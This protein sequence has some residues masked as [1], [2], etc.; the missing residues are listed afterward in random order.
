MSPTALV[1][2]L[3]HKLTLLATT[4]GLIALVC[5]FPGEPPRS[6]EPLFAAGPRTPTSPA[7]ASSPS[8][9]GLGDLPELP[10]LAK[11]VRRPAQ[12]TDKPRTS[13]ETL[14]AAL[15]YLPARGGDSGYVFHLDVQRL[16]ESG[17]L[18]EWGVREP[19][20]EVAVDEWRFPAWALGVMDLRAVTLFAQCEEDLDLE[21][22]VLA[23]ETNAISRIMDLRASLERD[24]EGAM[25]RLRCRANNT[26][27]GRP[28]KLDVTLNEGGEY[29]LNFKPSTRLDDS[30]TYPLYSVE[31]SL[32]NLW[33]DQAF[34][35]PEEGRPFRLG[36]Y[37]LSNGTE[38]RLKNTGGSGHMSLYRTVYHE[39]LHHKRWRLYKVKVPSL[40]GSESD[41]FICGASPKVGLIAEKSPEL[42]SCLDHHFKRGRSEMMEFMRT[43]D[44]SATAVFALN[45]PELSWRELTGN[46]VGETVQMAKS[47]PGWEPEFTRSLIESVTSVES[48]AVEVY[49]EPREVVAE[50]TVRVPDAEI[51]ALVIK[52]WDE[53]ALNMTHRSEL[54]D[55][56]N[57]TFEGYV[58]RQVFED[59]TPRVEGSTIRGSVRLNRQTLSALSPENR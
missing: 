6:P 43:L 5:V 11:F 48:A 15:S 39:P 19:L 41:S 46:E 34:T 57:E 37:H 56:S 25:Q 28:S 3:K 23:I 38:I 2:T 45:C 29:W 9:A 54:A 44:W 35:R 55:L 53:L 58:M 7:R 8:P 32:G 16:F 59:L 18:E 49:I 52:F 21:D 13:Q 20:E 24:H 47:D 31:G 12:P 1:L 42:Q 26:S 33:I 51:G 50:I 40:F 30:G 36:P 14:P 10:P 17:L 4:C 27:Y 22:P